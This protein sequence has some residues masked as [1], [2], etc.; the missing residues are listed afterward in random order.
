MATD[1]SFCIQRSLAKNYGVPLTR[2]TPI[3]PYSSGYT[4]YQLDMRRK[5][6]VL[7]FNSNKLSTQTNNLTKKE[8]F[9]LLVKNGLSRSKAVIQS[10]VINCNDQM[11]MVPT[12]NSG[13][14]GP[15]TYLFEDTT[16]PLYNYS[17]FNTRNYPN[18]ILENLEPWQFVIHSDIPIYNNASSGVYY[19]IINNTVN[20]DKYNYKITMPIGLSIDFNFV[21]IPENIINV[22]ITDI[23][24]IIY[25]EGNLKYAKKIQPTQNSLNDLSNIDISLNSPQFKSNI[26]LGNLIFD[27]VELY[28]TPTYVYK[29]ILT[30]TFQIYTNQYLESYVSLIANM[31]SSTIYTNNGGSIIGGTNEL[32]LGASISEK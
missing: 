20:R 5:A 3:N 8:K 19:L 31:K 17:D 4:K 27:N 23:N 13:V 12:C 10:N 18:Y 29:F 15:V 26:F 32:N 28:T 30:A 1:S 6:E 14:P 9:A 11:M 2:Y 7:K 25:Y 22:K 21:S 24:L 16:V